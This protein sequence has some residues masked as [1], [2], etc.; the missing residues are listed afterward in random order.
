MQEQNCLKLSKV[1]Y[2]FKY[3]RSATY[4]KESAEK[5]IR[6]QCLVKIL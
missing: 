2:I 1:E 5:G 4:E 3:T 6:S